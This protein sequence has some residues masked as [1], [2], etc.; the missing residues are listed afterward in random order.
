MFGLQDA[1][2]DARFGGRAVYCTVHFNLPVWPVCRAGQRPAL[3]LHCTA[4]SESD[5]DHKVN[6]ILNQG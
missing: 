1:V 4:T 6:W 2:Q 5:V 3:Q